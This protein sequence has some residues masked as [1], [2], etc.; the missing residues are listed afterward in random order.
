MARFNTGDTVVINIDPSVQK[1]QPYQR[2]DGKTG[3]VIGKQ[4]KAYF[5]RVSEG[6]STREVL[7]LPVHLKRIGG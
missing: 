2:S 3:K 7:S 4:G 1:G 5:I 6:N